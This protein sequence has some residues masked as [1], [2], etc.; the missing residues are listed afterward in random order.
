MKLKLIL[1]IAII[2]VLPLS[3]QAQPKPKKMTK[4]DA[5]KV[6]KMISGDKTKVKIYC[7]MAKLGDDM[8]Q[9]QEKKD[10]KKADEVSKKMDDMGKQLGPEYVALM[11]SMQSLN[12]KEAEAMGAAFEPLDKQCGK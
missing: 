5:E 6:V 2:A 11:E 4:A 12:E 8:Q 10:T 1:A 3:V 7:D 9:A